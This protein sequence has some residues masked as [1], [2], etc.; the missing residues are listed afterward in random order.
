MTLF[1]GGGVAQIRIARPTDRLAE[2]EHFYHELIGLPKLT[3]WRHG[4]DG[5]HHGYDGLIL[6]MPDG[7]MHLEFTHHAQGSPAPTPD[8]D[9]LL[10][11][12]LPDADH[13]ARVV[14][15]LHDAGVTEV[16]PENPWW[17]NGGH[18]FADPDGWRVVFM[19]GHGV[20][21]R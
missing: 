14:R 10:V 11:F 2:L 19:R 6:G 16:P 13:L 1:E 20:E 9:A 12:Y 4:L 3:S 17:A 18:T 5:D 7:T 15:R 21:K 8:R